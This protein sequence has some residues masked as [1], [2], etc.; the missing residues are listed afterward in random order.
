MY[1]GLEKARLKPFKKADEKV[2]RL[3]LFVPTVKI[4]AFHLVLINT[5]LKKRNRFF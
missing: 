1:V 2:V 4:A 3:H 5:Y